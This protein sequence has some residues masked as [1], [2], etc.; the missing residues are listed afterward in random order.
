[1][2]IIEYYSIPIKIHKYLKM[3]TE[4]AVIQHFKEG[5]RYCRNRSHELENLSGKLSNAYDNKFVS[6]LASGRAALH[7]ILASE[8]MIYPG[9]TLLFNQETHQETMDLVEFLHTIYDFKHSQ[10]ALEIESQFENA[11][12]SE[13]DNIFVLFLEAS[14]KSIF[15]FNLITKA[16]TWCQKLIVVV[17][18]QYLP[19]QVVDQ[20]F[21]YVNSI[22]MSIACAD[23][24]AI[25]AG[26]LI[27]DGETFILSRDF[28]KL[29]GSHVPPE[30]CGK[31]AES[32]VIDT[33][34]KACVGSHEQE[35]LS[36]KLTEE[37]GKYAMI[38]P[39]GNAA[40]NAALNVLLMKNPEA[41][42]I[43]GDELYCDTPRIMI[44]VLQKVYQTKLHEIFVNEISEVIKL[45]HPDKTFILVLETCSNPSGDI[46][47]FTM[48]SKL[49]TM[50]KKLI[51]VA[52]NTWLTGPILNPFD[53][54]VDIVP[55]SLTKYYSGSQC[56]AGAIMTGED[57]S[58]DICTYLQC[59]GTQI[60]SKYCAM[61]SA[62]HDTLKDRLARSS[63]LTLKAVRLLAS[64]TNIVVRHPSLESDRSHAKASMFF[65][66]GLYPSVVSLIINKRKNQAIKWMKKSGFNY[67]TSYGGPDTRCDPY[68]EQN[69]DGSTTC[70]LAL[71]YNDDEKVVLT[72]LA[73]MLEELKKS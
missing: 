43:C 39:S 29:Q 42:I 7:G 69:K 46:F 26:V 5:W 8:F 23:N 33:W 57:L 2:I 22:V 63:S 70:R 52:D 24:L 37:Y 61:I 47:D 18:A 48:I 68:P 38:T 3:T 13:P 21:T 66:N 64:G 67:W 17:D 45:M 59:I 71:G 30:F 40:M 12:K 10:I 28:V 50:C 31:L 73:R 1:M 55:V 44:D 14:K 19:L 41:E 51:V 54:D 35:M 25:T 6:V 62:S 32:Y 58:M 20:A 27:N 72:V 53:Y 9:A 36:Q 34:R 60:S 16:R 4:N 56:I 65:K 11:I 15:D 49:R